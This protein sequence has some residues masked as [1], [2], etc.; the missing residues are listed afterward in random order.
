MHL[1]RRPGSPVVP[2]LVRGDQP[3]LA[4]QRLQ[5]VR[6]HHVVDPLGQQHHLLDPRPA[7]RRREVRADPLRRLPRGADVEHLVGAAAEQVDAGRR[8]QVVGQSAACGA[9]RG[10]TSRTASCS[11][12]SECTPRLPSRS[13]N[14]C[15]TSTVALASVSARWSGRTRRAEQRRQPRPAGRW[16]PPPGDSARRA[17]R[18]V[19]TTAG[20]G[21]GR[22][23]PGAGGAQE[24]DVES[25]VVRHQ[26]GAP[27][28]LQE[29]RQHRLDAAARRP[30]IT[31]GDAGQHGDLRRNR[32]APG[33]PEWRTRR[34]PHRRAP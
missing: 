31:I 7:L 14:A 20:A 27:N 5:R 12:A 9:D 33:R 16:A 13:N 21:Q 4:D 3:L 28:E 29:R 22:P 6:A 1:V 32:P 18:T 15:R 2:R 25:G 19:S 17:S 23:M 30:T 24:P 10:T 34:A 26:H 11:S 8:R